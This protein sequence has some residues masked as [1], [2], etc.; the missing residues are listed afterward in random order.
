VELVV[1]ALCAATGSGGNCSSSPIAPPNDLCAAS[2]FRVLSGLG[3]HM[4]HGQDGIGPMKSSRLV[5]REE[6]VSDESTS[7]LRFRTGASNGRS[8]GAG[9]RVLPMQKG[10]AICRPVR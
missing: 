7:E 1:G 8:S 10:D 5:I 4:R 6:I 3:L 9:L 2:N